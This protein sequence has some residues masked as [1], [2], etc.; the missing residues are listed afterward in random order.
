MRIGKCGEYTKFE[1]NKTFSVRLY[2]TIRRVVQNDRSINNN[3]PNNISLK[4]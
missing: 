1:Q 3:M 4:N 2:S